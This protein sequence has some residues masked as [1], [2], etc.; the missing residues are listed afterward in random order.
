MK[1]K[2]LLVL[3]VLLAAP[4]FAQT[5]PAPT[6]PEATP[7]QL[8]AI[9]ATV[10]KQRDSATAT[11]QNLQIDIQLLQQEIESLRKQV[12]DLTAKLAAVAPKLS[13]AETETKPSPK[14]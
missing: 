6:Q 10:I 11:A 14:S 12:A 13:S 5:A 7:E 9:A 8:R 1:T 4:L 3:A 2:S